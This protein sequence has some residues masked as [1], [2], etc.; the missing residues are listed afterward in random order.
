[1]IIKCYFCIDF[2]AVAGG[3]ETDEA[4]AAAELYITVS[5]LTGRFLILLLLFC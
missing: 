5:Q 1:M 4:K 2:P 3:E